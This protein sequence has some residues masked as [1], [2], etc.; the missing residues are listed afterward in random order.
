VK[1]PALLT[2]D[3]HLVADPACAYRWELWPWLRQTIKDERVKTLCILGDMVDRKDNHPAVLVNRVCDELQRL[4]KDTGVE[5]VAMPGNHDWLKDG[6]EFW[7]FLRHMP[8]IHYPIEPWEHP[9]TKGPLC[10]FLPFTRDPMEAWKNLQSLEHYEYVF[11][12]QTVD[13]AIASN[14]QHMPGEPLPDIFAG[15]RKV[16]SG[17]IH[18]PQIVRTRAVDVEYVGSPYHVHFGDDFKA[19]VV[20]LEQNGN[21]VD[22]HVPNMPK[23]IIVKASSILQLR[24]LILEPGDQVKVRLNLRA[25]DR[26]QWAALRRE[27]MAWLRNRNV[28]VSGIELTSVDG[29]GQRITHNRARRLAG[30]SPDDAIARYVEDEDLGGDALQVGMELL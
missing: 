25:E 13:G 10:M 19:R 7:A 30:M 16:Y 26:Y 14:G 17:D 3:L 23:R 24:S 9:D 11:M 29:D 27:S 8:N 21:A 15:V 12:H 1:L 20:L 2:A 4:V 22:L 6:E 18:V 28:N 5:V